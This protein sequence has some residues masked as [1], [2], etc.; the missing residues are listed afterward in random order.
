MTGHEGDRERTFA[1]LPPAQGRGFAQTWWGRAWLRALEDA[2]LDTGQVKTGR[3]LAR[4]GAV[5]AVSVRPGR[6]TAVVQN[7]DR[8]THRADVLLAELPAEQW[9]RFLD[10]ALERAGDVA[11]LLDREMPPHLV[12]DAAAAGIELLPGLGDLEPECDCGAWDHCGHTAALCYQVARLLDQDP[13]VLLLMR[14]RGEHALLEDIQAR[15]AAPAEE[16]PG[17]EGVDAAEAYA[18]GDILPPLPAPPEL[19]E[20]PGLPP[21]LDT[22]APPGPGLDPVAVRHLA[23]RTAVEAHRLLAVALRQRSSEPLPPVTELTTAQDAVRLAVAAPDQA[24]TER[25]AG[26]SGRDPRSLADATRAWELEGAD[27]LSVLEDQWEPSG[28][29]LA[30]ARAA[31]DSAWDED[32]RPSLTADGNRWTVVGAPAQVRLGRD[33]RWWPYREEGGRWMLAGSA[34][35]DPATA[36][37]SAEPVSAEPQR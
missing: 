34:A 26:G 11:A 14:G 18:A 7:R 10:M 31:L 32:E 6:I 16:A 30:R 5:G 28:A 36:L 9:D 2:A 3:A 33:G 4:A 21:S 1:A 27:A 15:G 24:L 17:P 22:E 13:F 35:L 8:T 23:G 29:A 37:A 25:L 20:E 12:E 19:P